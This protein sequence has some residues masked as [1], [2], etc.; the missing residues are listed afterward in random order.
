MARY[1]STLIFKTPNIDKLAEDGILFTQAYST[2]QC[3]P[4]RASLLTGQHTARN[5]M[6]HV[7]P[8][9]DFPNAKMQEPEY[10]EDL[11]RQ[12]YTL[13]EVLKDNGYKTAIFISAS[14]LAFFSCKYS[15]RC[16]ILNLIATITKRKP[17]NFYEIVCPIVYFTF[18]VSATLRRWAKH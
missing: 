2:P 17:G 7:V 4:T 10:L 11:P 12:S 15:L 3:T 8:Y 18:F 14:I 1:L 9:Y 13:G 5:K 16:W 6:W